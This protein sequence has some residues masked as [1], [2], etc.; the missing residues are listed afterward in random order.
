MALLAL[1]S[2]ALLVPGAAFLVAPKGE[3][4][5][6]SE[7]TPFPSLKSIV[8]PSPEGRKSLSSAIFD[9]SSVKY[10]AISLRNS[11]SYSV[12]GAIESSEVVSGSPGWLFYKPEF[13]RWGC[14]RRAT[15]DDELARAETILD[16]IEAAKANVTFVSAPNKASI[17]SS[18]LAGSA[19][20]YAPCYFD[21]ES[22]FRASLSRYPA[23]VV[24]DHAQALEALGGDAQRYYYMDTHWTPMGGYAAIAQL[25]ASLPDALSGSIP[26]IESQEPAMRRTDLGNIMLRF[27]SQEPSVNLVLEPTASPE[28]GAGVLIVH[29]SFYGI[30]APQL[31]SAFPSATLSKLNGRAPPDADTLR[32]FDHIIIESVERQFLARMNLSWT[33]PDSLTFGWGSPLGDHILDQSQLLAEQCNWDEAVNIIEDKQSHALVRGMEFISSSAVRSTA[34]PRIMFRLPPAQGRL[35]CLEAEFSHPTKTRTQLYFERD[36]PGDGRSMFAEPQSV[37]RLV[38]PGR[39]RISWVIPQSALG[40]MARFDPVQDGDFELNSLRYAYGPDF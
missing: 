38:Q 23:T 4:V 39:S 15:L 1:F 8:L 17:E 33:R 24:I 6:S 11:L 26:A 22:D 12:L 16:M 18:R 3:T 19:A 10:N 40:R 27:R 34:D 35:V 21:F 2:F 9:R 20:R 31:K 37:F 28:S 30:V 14:S 7:P 25:R 29:D 32:K 13:E 36:T 5:L